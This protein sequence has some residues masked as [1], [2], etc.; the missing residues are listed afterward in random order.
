M[1]A[2][3]LAPLATALQMIE[4]TYSITAALD[5][6]VLPC[7]GMADSSSKGSG[8]S[9]HSYMTACTCTPWCHA[10]LLAALE[11]TV[12]DLGVPQPIPVS[13]AAALK[14]TE[15]APLFKPPIA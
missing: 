12:F 4:Q 13:R 11:L 7:H 6:A 8:S 15:V 1:L 14:T 2:V 10:A 9:S 5:E 3:T